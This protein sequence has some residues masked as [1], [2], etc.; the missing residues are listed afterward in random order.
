MLAIFGIDKTAGDEIHCVRDG[1]RM[2]VIFVTSIV[3]AT[4]EFGGISYVTLV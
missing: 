1:C 4:M 3:P 2:I